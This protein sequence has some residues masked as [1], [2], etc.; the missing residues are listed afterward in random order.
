ME[1]ADVNKYDDPTLT[2]STS[3]KQENFLFNRGACK[4]FKKVNFIFYI[5]GHTKNLC[6]RWFNT[7]KRNYRL[8]NIYTFPD[9]VD[10]FKTND[11]ITIH[12]LQ[13]GDFRDWESCLNRLYQRITGIKKSHIFVVDGNNPDHMV[14]DIDTL[15]TEPSR[16]LKMLKTTKS[17]GQQEN[18]DDIVNDSNDGD[19]V[20]GRNVVLEAVSLF[21]EHDGSIR[22]DDMFTK[23]V[24]VIKF[25]G[26]REIKFVEMG[27][28]YRKLVPKKYHSYWMYEGATSE[29]IER[30]K[31]EK[32]EKLLRKRF[33]HPNCKYEKRT[34]VRKKFDDKYYL[35]KVVD[36]V[37]NGGYYKIVYSDG[38]NED[39][40]EQ[41]M[42]DHVYEDSNKKQKTTEEGATEDI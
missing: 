27:T 22:D 20:A 9:M 4:F 13:P 32:R 14:I 42:R 7:L 18:E 34:V 8:T 35:G 41:E 36:Y 5:V 40:D 31:L 16:T 2:T 11:L 23:Y 24:P 28:K 21:P 6:D 38:D 3:V 12:T 30:N 1:E 33:A 17:K 15:G 19:V 39:M 25:P 29:I 26:L 37:V 10:Q